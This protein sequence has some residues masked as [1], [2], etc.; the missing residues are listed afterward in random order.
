MK[1]VFAA[2]QTTSGK[3][4]S[5]PEM[6]I[7]QQPTRFSSELFIPRIADDEMISIV[8]WKV[9]S[10]SPPNTTS[11]MTRPTGEECVQGSS[12]RSYRPKT[13]ETLAFT[14]GP[15]FLREAV[16]HLMARKT[17]LGFGALGKECWNNCFVTEDLVI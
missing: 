12:T 5:S 7:C 9:S 14:W 8:F 11:V 15:C 6:K 2:P 4:L 13:R 16:V 3:R 17:N 10:A 1:V